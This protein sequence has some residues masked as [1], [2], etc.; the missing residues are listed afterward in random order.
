MFLGGSPT[1]AAAFAVVGNGAMQLPALVA[2]SKACVRFEG[3]SATVVPG[4][5]GIAVYL[6]YIL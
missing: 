1:M 3:M 4:N 5:I 2:S 6:G